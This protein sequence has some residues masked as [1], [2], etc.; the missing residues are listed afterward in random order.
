M[1]RLQQFFRH[2]CDPGL[3]STLFRQTFSLFL[4]GKIT[5]AVGALLLALLLEKRMPS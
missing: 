5:A 2:C 1:L 4:V 3:K